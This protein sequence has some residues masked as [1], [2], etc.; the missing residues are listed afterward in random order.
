MGRENFGENLK[1]KL[2]AEE[3]PELL[4]HGSDVADIENLEPRK[5]FTP[6]GKDVPERIYAGDNPAFAAAH[7]FPWGSAEGFRL[8]VEEGKVV[9][10]VPKKFKDRLTKK[11]YIYKLPSEKFEIT[12]EE[13]TGHTFHSQEAVKPIGVEEFE[14]V[15][16]AIEH[17]GG[18]VSYIEDEEDK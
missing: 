6:A 3:K 8:S 4:F 7:S 9:F 13:E 12:T 1:E 16:D 5:R 11:V 14:S 15:Q 17:F 2:L 18:I 10:E